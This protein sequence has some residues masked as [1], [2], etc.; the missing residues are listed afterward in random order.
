VGYAGSLEYVLDELPM[1]RGWALAAWRVENNPWVPVE[2]IGSG[3]IAQ[4]IEQRL[5]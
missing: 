5:L 2:R 3:Y 4:D 1:A